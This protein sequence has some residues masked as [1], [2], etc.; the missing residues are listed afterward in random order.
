VV[1]AGAHCGTGGGVVGVNWL[2]GG[3]H[4]REGGKWVS[5]VVDVRR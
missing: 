2:Q 5:G 4:L 3:G 1:G